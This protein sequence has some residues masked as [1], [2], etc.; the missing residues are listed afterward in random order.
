M[1]IQYRKYALPLISLVL[2]TLIGCTNNEQKNDKN[3]TYTFE[4]SKKRG[5]VIEK[6][7]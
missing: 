5:D 1:R 3:E 7:R 4:A 2:F 6:K